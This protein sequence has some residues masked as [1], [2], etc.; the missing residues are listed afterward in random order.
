MIEQTHI[1]MGMPITLKAVHDPTTH[2]VFDKTFLFF[3]RIDQLYSPFIAS[4]DV[5][6]INKHELLEADYSF[7]LQEILNYGEKTKRDTNGYFD[8]WHDGVLDPSG[9][10]KGWSIQKASELMAKVI[11]NFYIDAGGDIQ[12][13][14]TNDKY[15]PWRIGIRN[16][17]NRSENIAIVSL[18][19]HAIATSGTATRGQHIYNP[20]SDNPITDIVSISVIA[21]NILDADRMATAA[22]AM[23]KQGIEFIEKLPGYEAY[24]VDSN[25]RAIMTTGWHAF[26]VDAT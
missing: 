22:F 13:K 15:Q 25:K 23:G 11:D 10:V 21:P 2:K 6:K 26:E 17:F 18:D 3:E 19:N 14:G 4:S 24:L 20:L 5:S 7:E 16:P 9:I 12:A 1:I 8:V